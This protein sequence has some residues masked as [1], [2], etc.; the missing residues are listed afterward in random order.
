MEFIPLREANEEYGKCRELVG[1]RPVAGDWF[2][3]GNPKLNKNALVTLGNS[4]LPHRKAGVV[5]R[6]LDLPDHVRIALRKYNACEHASPLCS[7]GCLNTAGRGKFQPIQY[8]RL[9]RT[10]LRICNEDAMYSLNVHLLYKALIKHDGNVARRFNVIS[11]EPWELLLPDEYWQR[12]PNVQHYDYTADSK[13]AE[14]WRDGFTYD[15]KRFPA[16]YH[17]TLSAKEHHGLEWIHGFVELGV[18]VAVVCDTPAKKP[19]PAEWFGLPAIDGD[20]SDE[21]WLDP[22]GV[23]VLLS[24]KGQARKQAVGWNQFVK[25]TSA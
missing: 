1:Y 20:L 15:G 23:V 9:A 6:G 8:A 12:F 14:L 16:N 5:A 4:Y 21:R 17:L 7:I 11:D 19:K 10:L 3:T 13:R 22:Q 25:P 18:N 2:T 24:A